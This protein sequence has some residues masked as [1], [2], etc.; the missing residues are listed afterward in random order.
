MAPRTGRPARAGGGMEARGPGGLVGSGLAEHLQLL[1]SG[2][3]GRAPAAFSPVVG[4][5]CLLYLAV[6]G[7]YLSC[8]R[9]PPLPSPPLPSPPLLWGRASARPEASRGPERGPGWR[10]SGEGLTIG[11]PIPSPPPPSSTPIPPPPYLG[12]HAEARTRSSCRRES[13]GCSRQS[14]ASWR[15]VSAPVRPSGTGRT[16]FWE[17]WGY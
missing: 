10:R 2:A 4:A 14:S 9:A 17:C 11:G 3:R 1:A 8:A 6:A 5:S 16:A 7:T 15:I 13:S 12:W